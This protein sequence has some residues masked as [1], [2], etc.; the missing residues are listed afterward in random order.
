M[1]ISGDPREYD[2]HNHAPLQLGDWCCNS[3][4]IL[5]SP[6]SSAR[7]IMDGSSML[8]L[9]ISGAVDVASMSRHAASPWRAPSFHVQLSSSL[10]RTLWIRSKQ[11]RIA[12]AVS[13]V[14]VD[15]HV[16]GSKKLRRRPEVTRMLTEVVHNLMVPQGEDM[17][18]YSEWIS[19]VAPGSPARHPLL[20][21]IYESSKV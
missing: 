6:H 9:R 14:S 13:F 8:L 21:I 15:A 20:P 2:V 3:R 12:L 19:E 4:V 16:L 17:E 7:G 1:V 10:T 11:D 18:S 5:P